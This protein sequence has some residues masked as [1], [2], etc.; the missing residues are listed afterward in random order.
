MGRAYSVDLR[1]RV[2]ASVDS[3]MSKIQAHRIFKVSRST[4]DDWIKLREQTGTVE[5]APRRSGGTGTK[6]LTSHESF[7]AFVERHRHS[8]LRQM[9]CAWQEETQQSLS[10]MSFSRALRTL[11]YTRKKRAT[12]TAS[13]VPHN[14]RSLHKR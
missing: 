14:V 10:L 1:L 7:T 9:Q 2:L 3:G 4:I 6:R 11:G 12:S 8:T 13:A 5:V